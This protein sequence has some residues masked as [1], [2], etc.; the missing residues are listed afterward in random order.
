M[1]KSDCN[2]YREPVG[3]LWRK[4]NVGQINNNAAATTGTATKSSLC[5]TG[6]SARNRK[7]IAGRF[8]SRRAPEKLGLSSDAAIERKTAEPPLRR[9]R[10]RLP[11]S[12]QTRIKCKLQYTC[13]ITTKGN[14]ASGRSVRSN[15]IVAVENK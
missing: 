2:K 5:R 4:V 7:I 10:L 6:W 12:K 11:S 13:R 14:T 3:S 1:L 15:C 8:A 9:K